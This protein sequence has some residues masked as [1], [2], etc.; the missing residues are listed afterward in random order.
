MQSV[1]RLGPGEMDGLV[2][3]DNAVA[4]RK[5][6]ADEGVHAVEI[7]RV[8]AKTWLFLGHETEIPNAGDF[9]VR[10]M[11]LAPVILVRDDNSEIRAFLNSCTHRGTLICRLDFGNTRAFVCPYHGWTFGTDGTLHSMAMSR[12]TYEER[13]DFETDGE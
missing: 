2:D 7:D 4:S 5:V 12:D 3:I 8:F 6:F 11:A 10:E 13:V 1:E 9:V